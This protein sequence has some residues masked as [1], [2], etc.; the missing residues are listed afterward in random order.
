LKLFIYSPKNSPRLEYITKLI[1]D[2]LIGVNCEIITQAEE[3]YTK[4][5]VVNYSVQE[6]VG[7]QIIPSKILFEKR[8]SNQELQIG[9]EADFTTLFSNKTSDFSF[10]ILGA[11]FFLVTRYEEY[12]PHKRDKHDRFEPEQ[13]V[14]YKE[15]FLN[16][17][18][19]NIWAAYLKQKLQ[20]KYPKLEFQSRSFSYINTIDVDYAYAYLEKGAIRSAG[21]LVRDFFTGNFSEFKNRLACFLGAKS[22]P[23]D[24][25]NYLLELHK[26]FNLNSIFFFHVGDYDV[27]D[28]SIPITS[29]KLQALIKGV[30]DYADVGIHPSYAANGNSEKLEAELIRLSRVVHQPITKSRN[31]FIKLNLPQSYRDL[32][33]LDVKKD[34]TMGYASKMGFRA[35]ICSPFYFYDLD[36]DAPTNLKVFPFYLM[37][38][39]IKYYF[40]EGP[41]KAMKYFEEYIDMVKKYN[42]TF[43]SLWHNDSLSEWGQWKGWS[44]IYV[45]MLEYLKE[46]S[47]SVENE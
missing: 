9:K 35:S 19:I 34:Y 31:H 47:T 36:Y 46:N 37:E 15:G 11:A 41:E 12:M 2:D 29:H 16:Q 17:P 25:F 1:F 4:E 14:A 10:D 20:E 8:I 40:K 27:H 38:A 30:K 18:I 7:L 21:A 39:T 24:T 22:D 13:S 28:K 42:G 32:I 43:V 6:S 5:F 45:K 44:S 33:E 23:F 26:K 3:V